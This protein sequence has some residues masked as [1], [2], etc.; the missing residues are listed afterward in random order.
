MAAMNDSTKRK[1]E[2][3]SQKKSSKVIAGAVGAVD[4]P[5]DLERELNEVT[6]YWKEAVSELRGEEF[7]T[8]ESAVDRVVQLASSKLEGVA[9][10]KATQ[11]FMKQALLSSDEVIQTLTS[12]L[13][14]KER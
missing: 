5:G 4:A 8:V 7:E 12:T 10:N 11:E 6:D 13:Q 14:I 9:D 1:A 2:E 3:K